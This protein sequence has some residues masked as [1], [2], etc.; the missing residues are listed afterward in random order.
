MLDQFGLRSC[1]IES[2][3]D[4]ALPVPVSS[5]PRVPEQLPGGGAP[6]GWGAAGTPCPPA[7]GDETGPRPGVRLRGRER[8]TG[9]GPLRHAWYASMSHQ[10]PTSPM[11]PPGI[12]L[13]LHL[14]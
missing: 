3:S 11:T 2:V 12:S 1:P 13:R 9:G 6:S 8:E 4:D 5:Q 14:P 10:L 7:G